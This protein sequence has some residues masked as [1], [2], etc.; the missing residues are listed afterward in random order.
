[1][2]EERKKIL[3]LVQEGKLSAQEALILLEALDEKPKL[4]ESNVSN[5]QT[6]NDNNEQTHHDTT[7]STGRSEEKKN[8]ESFYT[9]LEN[10]GER[11]FDF[12]NNALNKIKHIDWQFNQSVDIPHTFEQIGSD[13][14]Q[15]D[16]DIANGPVRI[17]SWD[18]K[19]VRIE[20]QAKV[21]RSEDREDARKY[22][23]ENTIFPVIMDFY[24]SQL[25][26]NGCV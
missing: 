6:F 12:V 14:E 4:A 13:I 16:I 11:I 3:N 24:A 20:C 1:M 23:L 10:A 15:I 5:G 26:R 22:F 9:Q 21:Y 8:E 2:S 25:N 7:T 19:E 18:Q 17:T